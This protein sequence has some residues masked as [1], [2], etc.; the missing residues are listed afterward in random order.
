MIYDSVIWKLELEKKTEEFRKLLKE[1]TFSNEWYFDENEDGDPRSYK[2]FIELQKYCFYSAVIIRKFL[3]SKRLSDELCATNYTIPCYKK[4]SDKK[5]SKRNFESVDDDYDLNTKFKKTLNLKRICDILI[6]SFI[7]SP[8]LLDVKI[9][10]NLED[11][12][13]DNWEIEGVSGIYINTD[14]SKEKEIYYFELD[15]ILYLFE[16]VYNDDII[17][18]AENRITGQV[19]RSRNQTKNLLRFF[20]K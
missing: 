4:K 12:L 20:W 10:K 19:V 11:D 9:D 13:E 1:T 17:Y 3:E 8:K 15:F 7:F 2:F 16:E 14:H 5:I 6:H 18:Y